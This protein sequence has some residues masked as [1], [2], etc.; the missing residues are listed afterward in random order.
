MALFCTSNATQMKRSAWSI[1]KPIQ[2]NVTVLEPTIQPEHSATLTTESVKSGGGEPKVGEPKVVEQV[3]S[4][5]ISIGKIADSKTVWLAE[6]ISCSVSQ[7]ELTVEFKAL[8]FKAV[9]DR[10]KTLDDRVK[11]LEDREVR[12]QQ[13]KTSVELIHDSL[14]DVET[15]KHDFNMLAP[16]VREVTDRGTAFQTELTKLTSKLHSLESSILDVTQDLAAI[17]TPKISRWSTSSYC[18][19]LLSAGV[20]ALSSPFVLQ[21][22][23]SAVTQDEF[24][25]HRFQASYT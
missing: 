3:G 1:D 19:G 16:F 9:D 12:I 11:T 25:T 22:I 6:N 14:S 18:V 23:S 8:L 4:W 5:D 15:L 10:V 7:P 13:I 20:L 24:N 17:Q 2:P 21:L